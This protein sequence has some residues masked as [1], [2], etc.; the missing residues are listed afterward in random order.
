MEEEYFFYY[1]THGSASQT[2]RWDSSSDESL[3][4]EE[5]ISYADDTQTS[6][7]P[8]E[9]IIHDT[10]RDIQGLLSDESDSSF[11]AIS[12]SSSTFPTSLDTSSSVRQFSTGRD[13]FF[14]RVPLLPPRNGKTYCP[15]F[16][17]TH[18]LQS[19]IHAIKEESYPPIKSGSL[20]SIHGAHLGRGDS[21]FKPLVKR[22]SSLFEPLSR[23]ASTFVEPFNDHRGRPKSVAQ[24]LFNLSLLGAVIGVI[25]PHNEDLPTPWYRI[26]SSVIGYTYFI[27]WCVSFWPQ[28]IMNYQRK[29]TEGLSID[30]SVINFFGFICYTAYTFMLY[31]NKAIREMY[32]E[33]YIS[34]SL[35]ARPPEIT[36][37]SNDVAYAIHALVLSMVW[38]IQLEIY[39]GFQKCR[40]EGKRIISKPMTA[41]IVFILVSCSAYAALIGYYHTFPDQHIFVFFAHWLNWL[42]YLYY[43]A[44]IKV[45][46]TAAKYVPQCILNMQRKSCVGWNI[47]NIL[48]DF[49]GG[50]F[51]LVQLL[52]DAIDL[53]D[54]SSIKGNSA[55]LALSAV[56]IIFD[57]SF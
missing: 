7:L 38:L 26:C 5:D 55:K 13:Q 17:D 31:W 28:V 27:F 36:V 51:S 21:F 54:L 57:V 56:S 19:S 37:E 49:A 34:D 23:R 25:M 35:D 22:S 11:A 41:L 4:S 52:G 42:D 2:R 12:A 45:F 33:R 39:G 3:E 50:I 10:D 18:S 32:I 43:V 40:D 30:Y 8:T 24:G 6:P 9:E 53:D 20:R 16:K 46:V 44:Y 15:M 48:L 47:W 14:E 29:S 1:L